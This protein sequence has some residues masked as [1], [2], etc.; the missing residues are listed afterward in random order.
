MVLWSQY[1]E[2]LTEGMQPT[3]GTQLL[4]E[5]QTHG[6]PDFELPGLDGESVRLSDYIANTTEDKSRL[7]IV[8][9]WASWCDPCIEEFPSFLRLIRHFDGRVI[10]MAVSN[11]NREDELLAFLQAFEGPHEH[12]VVAWDKDRSVANQFGTEVLPESYIVGPQG[13]LIRKVAGVET[14]DSPMAIDFFEDLLSG[15]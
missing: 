1:S 4:N 5:M 13:K 10:L 9:F 8:N 14:W 11:D 15:N 2:K 3:R 7:V 6:V 12:L